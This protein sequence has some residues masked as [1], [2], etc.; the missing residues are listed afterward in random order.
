MQVENSSIVKALWLLITIKSIAK[1]AFGEHCWR[2]RGMGK[3]QL[4]VMTCQQGRLGWGIYLLKTLLSDYVDINVV[5][6]NFKLKPMLA[7]PKPSTQR[8]L[9][10]LRAHGWQI[11]E[12]PEVK[13]EKET[14]TEAL[15][16]D[17]PGA[18][19]ENRIKDC[20]PI[21]T[22]WGAPGGRWILKAGSLGPALA[23]PQLW[24]REPWHQ[25]SRHTPRKRKA[26]WICAAY[27]FP[28]KVRGPRSPPSVSAPNPFTIPGSIFTS[29]SVVM[30]SATLLWTRT[31][32]RCQKKKKKKGL[33]V[34]IA[35]M[36][37]KKKN[38]LSCF[39]FSNSS[40]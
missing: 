39:L 36:C 7:V 14:Q 5:R 4:L 29:L 25:D 26:P 23:S 16:D 38:Q 33:P 2:E 24:R 18:V 20:N 31:C 6:Y 15:G 9:D 19:L 1:W 22:F 13:K 21:P 37:L 28:V 3:S 32:L 40:G 10:Y 17:P 8:Q 27:R 11:L 34:Q 30:K 35:F 12:K